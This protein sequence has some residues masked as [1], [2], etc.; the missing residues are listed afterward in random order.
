[1]RFERSWDFDLAVRI[2]PP[3][4]S[5]KKERPAVDWGYTEG[6]V[7][8]CLIMKSS[9]IPRSAILAIILGIVLSVA[10]L[11]AAELSA[12]FLWK[13]VL[14]PKVEYQSD[15]WYLDSFGIPMARP[16]GSFRST[17]VSE[18]TGGVIYDVVY[19]IDALSRRITPMVDH[20]Q[21]N[22][23]L[24]FFGGFFTYAQG[25]EGDETIPF[26]TASRAKHFRPYNYAFHGSGATEMLAR[27]ESRSLRNEVTEKKGIL[28]CAFIPAHVKRAIGS[29]RVAGTWGR[30]HPYYELDASGVLVR[31][32][33]FSGRSSISSIYAV[34]V[35]SKLL[36]RFEVD[37]PI[38]LSEKHYHLTT[39]V[40]E[41]ARD[42]YTEQFPGGDFYVLIYPGVSDEL[43]LVSFLDDI[44]IE[45]LNYAALFDRTE[46]QYWLSPEDKHPSALA[47]Q[48]VADKLVDDLNLY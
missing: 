38:R 25:L 26:Y 5:G 9:V 11:M 2:L 39:Q 35:R 14:T 33:T 13:Q 44:G 19:N 27:L 40:I 4:G 1:M 3:C 45:Y 18:S 42:S 24:L 37:F 48:I 30:D 23:F 22:D 46:S 12:R 6:I 34:L 28:I 17:S 36:E 47:N 31:K 21:R 43:N 16:N 29:M 32:G 7:N 15:Y 10:L 8:P 20:G 41:R